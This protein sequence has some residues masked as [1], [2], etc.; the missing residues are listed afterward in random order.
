MKIYA[1]RTI[2]E[3]ADFIDKDIWV[4]VTWSP[5]CAA[6]WLDI[7]SGLPFYVYFY[8]TPDGTVKYINMTTTLSEDLEYSEPLHIQQQHRVVDAVRATQRK[9]SGFDANLK[10]FMLVQPI[11]TLT[12]DELLAC[13][14]DV[15]T[16][17]TI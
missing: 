4:K 14:P 2:R 9:T 12:N 17:E 6:A 7:F 5:E 16:G 8:R 11:E 13:A 15:Y 3:I 1:S 10:D